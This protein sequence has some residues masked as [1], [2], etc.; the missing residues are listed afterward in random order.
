MP[1]EALLMGRPESP[2]LWKS[3]SAIST[4]YVFGSDLLTKICR[5]ATYAQI[6]VP[7]FDPLCPPPLLFNK[8]YSQEHFFLPPLPNLGTLSHHTPDKLKI[9]MSHTKII[10]KNKLRGVPVWPQW[11]PRA[12]IA[13]A[14]WRWRKVSDAIS[15]FLFQYRFRPLDKTGGTSVFVG[16]VS[17]HVVLF[18]EFGKYVCISYY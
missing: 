18:F 16:Q 5:F 4:D 9:S 14:G 6:R 12:E 11:G 3:H 8:S 17:F 15:I 13:F 7:N 10:D 1:F 2:T